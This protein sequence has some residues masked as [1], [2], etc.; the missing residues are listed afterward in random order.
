MGMNDWRAQLKEVHQEFK[1]FSKWG[2]IGI[3][4]GGALIV[5]AV[6]LVPGENLLAAV[7]ALGATFLGVF[8]SFWLERRRQETEEKRQFARCIG[9]I[10]IESG[11]N[12]GLLRG[13]LKEADPGHLPIFEM[14]TEALR[15]A[16]IHPLFYKWA[17]QSLVLATTTVRTE[18]VN[19][20]N[21]L[22]IYREAV[23]TGQALTEK[24]AEKLKVRAEANLER[25]RAM[26]KPLNEAL[27]KFPAPSVADRPFG[28]ANKSLKGIANWQN[29]KL[30]GIEGE[31]S[32]AEGDA[33]AHETPATAES[34]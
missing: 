18:L 13:L 15:T 16:L 24:T 11:A 6:L 33:A 5:L 3:G 9:A 34:G 2:R 26:E 23:A 29:A 20:N 25:L 7:L 31:E 4:I 22:M 28:E 14:Q 19:L 17:D 21:L 8:L 27:R 10:K 32:E 30:A 1:G 12:E